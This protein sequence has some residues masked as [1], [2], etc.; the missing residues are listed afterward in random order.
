MTAHPLE[1]LREFLL[2]AFGWGAGATLVL[3]VLGSI[4]MST[5]VLRRVEAI[6]RAS[7]RIMAGE[8]DRRLP[9]TIGDRSRS[10]DEFDRLAA[11]LNVMLD[12]IAGV[13]SRDGA[14]RTC[15]SH[16]RYTEM[17]RSLPGFAAAGTLYL[18]MFAAELAF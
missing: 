1:E 3:A 4:G 8:L 12:R 6:N 2:G 5:G 15:E 10:G 17:K 7:E 16:G 13:R 18:A 9:T 14:R 11:N